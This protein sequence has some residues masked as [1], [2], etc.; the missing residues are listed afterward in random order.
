MHYIIESRAL[1][2]VFLS[3]KGIYYQAEIRGELVTWITPYS[4]SQQVPSPPPQHTHTNQL[5]SLQMPTDVDFRVMLTFVEFYATLMGF[6]NYRIF[7]SLNL[8]YP[9]QVGGTVG[10]ASEAVL[11]LCT[12]LP[13]P[14]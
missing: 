8:K 9:P 5:L 11:T 14:D 4:F 13:P 12:S 10:G 2:K 7:S 3:I 1:R 6:V